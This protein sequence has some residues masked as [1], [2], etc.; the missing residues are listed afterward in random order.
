MQFILKADWGPAMKQ[1][2]LAIAAAAVA[3][4]VAG[5][6][7]GRAVHQLND[8]LA[9]AWA[10]LIAP[11]AP[12]P[13]RPPARPAPAPAPWP[14]RDSAVPVPVLMGGIV[15]DEP[16][17]QVLILRAQGLSQRQ[18]AAAMGVSR[19]KVRQALAA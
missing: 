14:A 16:E 1:A 7:L 15:A 8:Q 11:A 13:P 10:G 17:Q 9:A 6:A 18:I 12:P 3:A 5:E 4:F 19:W 2:A